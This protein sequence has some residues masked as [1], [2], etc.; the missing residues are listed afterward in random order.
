MNEQGLLSGGPPAADPKLQEAAKMYLA[1]G[2]RL[3][4][5][6]EI[7]DGI[8]KKLQTVDDPIPQ[9]ADSTLDIVNR[10]ESGASG[11]GVSLP[12]EYL[13]QVANVLMGEII[14]IAEIAGAEPLSEEERYKAFSL[15]VSKYLSNAVK[16][17]RI[18]P[19]QLQQMKQQAMQSPQGQEI[20]NK[21][22]EIKEA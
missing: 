12:P 5:S 17:G 6:E 4:H 16:T 9:I 18:S 15:A 1:N 19:D 21:V 7:S 11:K 22:G 10:I 8:I 3:I 2:L 14:S 13:A 20:V